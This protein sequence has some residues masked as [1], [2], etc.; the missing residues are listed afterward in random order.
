MDVDVNP[1]S[2]AVTTQQKN[3]VGEFVPLQILQAT[4]RYPLSDCT[5][6]TISRFLNNSV[7]RHSS[8]ELAAKETV[9]I[10]RLD[11]LAGAVPF[12]PIGVA[13]GHPFLAKVLVAEIPSD[14]SLS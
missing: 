4:E 12:A 14:S 9:A 8:A 7:L 5:H 6:V 2:T 11:E 13:G 10:R 1:I 3:Q